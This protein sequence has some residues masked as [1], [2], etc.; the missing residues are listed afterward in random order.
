MKKNQSIEIKSFPD[1]YS[2]DGNWVLK[3]EITNLPQPR[4]D[5]KQYLIFKISND[6][7]RSII[8]LMSLGILWILYGIFD[9]KIFSLLWTNIQ[10]LNHSI[11]TAIFLFISVELIF[12]ITYYYIDLTL[13]KIERKN[14]ESKKKQDLIDIDTQLR[15]LRKKRHLNYLVSNSGGLSKEDI[16]LVTNFFGVSKKKSVADHFLHEQDIEKLDKLINR[17]TTRKK[18]EDTEALS[19]IKNYI[20]SH[21]QDIE[22]LEYK[23]SSIL[24]KHTEISLEHFNKYI[25]FMIFKWFYPLL[26]WFISLY[27]LYINYKVDF[28]FFRNI[29]Y[30]I[31]WLNWLLIILLILILFFIWINRF[32]KNN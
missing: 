29:Y 22:N 19:Y 18:T 21:E 15:N 30:W 6:T 32:L 10:G 26:I 28:V 13:H 9:I 3:T 20:Q 17:F 1:E 14:I 2:H 7:N 11:S 27:F 16:W 12:F 5:K 4:V 31:W 8:K 23:K 24:L 25:V